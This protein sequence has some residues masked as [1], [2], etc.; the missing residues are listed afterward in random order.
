[1]TLAARFGQSLTCL[2]G[3]TAVCKIGVAVSGGSD[4]TALLHL[5]ADWARGSGCKI[6]AVT[7]DHRMRDASAAE[8]RQVAG[9]CAA[10]GISHKTLIWEGRESHGN[11]QDQARQARYRLISEWA[12]GLGIAH[13]TLGHT[14]DDQ[15]ETVL[16][17]LLRGSGVDGLSAIPVVRSSEQVHW[18][19]PVL[20]LGREELRACLRELGVDWSEDPSNLD[21]KYDRVKLRNALKILE[22]LGFD[23]AGLAET[24]T[25]LAD[26]RLVLEQAA[27]RALKEIATTRAGSVFFETEGLRTLPKETRRRV[28]AHTLCWISGNP[29]P[30]RHSALLRLEADIWDMSTTTLHGCLITPKNEQ[31]IFG[32]EPAAISDICAKPTELWDGRWLLS[33]PEMSGAEIRMIGDKGLKSCPEWRESGLDRATVLATPAVWNGAELL[34]APLAGLSNGWRA[35]LKQNE[36]HFY[37]SVLSH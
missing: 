25:R 9:Q 12:R 16:M 18:L 7:V 31:I 24:A 19:R 27:L 5:V 8:A 26:A 14:R 11:F 28:M 6:F 22:P 17:R 15:A 36:D 10:L 34:A 35:K 37:S 32:R 2:L 3:E 1:M 4:S 23:A 29:Y 20:G 13:V 33:G 21:P 30:P